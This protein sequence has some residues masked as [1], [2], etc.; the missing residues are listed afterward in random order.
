MIEDIV[1][2]T[3]FDNAEIEVIPEWVDVGELLQLLGREYLGRANN[4][5]CSIHCVPTTAHVF[6]DP[7]LLKRILRN[8]I[9]NVIKHSDAT[10]LLLGVRRRKSGV[11][12]WVA[13]NGIGLNIGDEKSTILQQS[14]SQPGLGLG[15]KI[16]KQLAAACGANL[17]HT[18]RSGEG[19]VFKLMIPSS[20]VRFD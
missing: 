9:I 1:Q 7:N 2:Y 17:T 10:K 5:D 6:V 13:D 16:S 18:S 4:A 20:A 12:I 19:T 14:T 11:E 15:V 3:H 8:L